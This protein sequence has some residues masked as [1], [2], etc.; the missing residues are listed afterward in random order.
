MS[1]HMPAKQLALVLAK[2]KGFMHGI[3]PKCQPS[4]TV[5]EPGCQSNCQPAELLAGRPVSQAQT[6]PP[7]MD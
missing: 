6:D 5:S 4:Q 7:P 3:S 1:P 2:V